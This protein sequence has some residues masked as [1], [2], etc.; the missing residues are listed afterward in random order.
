MICLIYVVWDI[1]ETDYVMFF[2][3]VHGGWWVTLPL[4]PTNGLKHVLAHDFMDHVFSLR[5]LVSFSDQH[6]Y[7]KNTE[8]RTAFRYQHG[9]LHARQHRVYRDVVLQL[10]RGAS[11]GWNSCGG[12]LERHGGHHGC[13]LLSTL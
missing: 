4:E 11:V 12:Q 9:L 2:V 6:G 5:I 1:Q 3:H 10:K 13:E 7:A 8:A